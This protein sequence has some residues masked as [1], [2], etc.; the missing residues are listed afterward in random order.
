MQQV[1]QIKFVSNILSLVRQ[2]NSTY[3]HQGNDGHNCLFP[4]RPDLIKI[5]FCWTKERFNVVAFTCIN[6]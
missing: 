5:G 1:A 4:V 2:E 6:F 3:S